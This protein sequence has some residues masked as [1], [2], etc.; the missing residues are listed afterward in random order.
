MAE[1]ADAG[2]PGGPSIA[3]ALRQAAAAGL[4]RFDAQRLMAHLTGRDRAWLMAHDDTRL[5][6]EQTARWADWVARRRDGVPVAYLT[7]ERGFHGLT[8]QV[9]PAV[10]DPRPDTETLVDWALARMAAADR[11][12]RV[13][14]LGTGS[15]AVALALKAARPDWQVTAT[16]RSHAALDVS[17]AN[18]ARLGLAV[19]WLAG[20]WF[21]A[22]APGTPP[23][24]LVV[25]NP[26]YIAENDPHL[27]ALVHE[28]R[29]ALVSGADGLDDLRHL[30]T[31]APAQLAPGGWLLLEHGFDQADAVAALFRAAGWSDPAHRLDLGG[32]RRCTGARRPGRTSA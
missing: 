19:D 13:L 26:P 15:G 7:G 27:A 31:A 32:H 18:G 10:L 4:E 21:D 17:R 23:F 14:D 11:P 16:D 20:D 12:G 5:G 24:D 22:L 1:A 9:G 3:E 8:L 6:S 29:T 2:R 28:P 25:S 30:V